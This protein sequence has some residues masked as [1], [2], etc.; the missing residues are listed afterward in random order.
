[1]QNYLPN[2]YAVDCVIFS[3]RVEY[4]Q[5]TH[6]WSSRWTSPNGLHM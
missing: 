6:K 2:L 4:L 5:D 3:N 1:M